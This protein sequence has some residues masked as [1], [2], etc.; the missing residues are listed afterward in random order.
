MNRSGYPAGGR[1]LSVKRRLLFWRLLYGVAR[2]LSRVSAERCR[3]YA[4]F[5]VAQRVEPDRFDRLLRTRAGEVREIGL[6]E[7]VTLPV[8]RPRS[9]I[10]GRFRQGARCL[11][12]R[13]DGEFQGFVWYQAGPY[14]EDEVRC[15]FVPEPATIAVWDFDVYVIPSARSG[16]TFARLWRGY[17]E[18][19]SSEGIEWSISRISAFNAPSVSAHATLGALHVGTACFIVLGALQIT[20]ASIAPFVHCSFGK[21]RRPVMAVQVPRIR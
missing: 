3:L 17:F 5:L 20:L 11:A 21:E 6:D 18:A 19:L 7:A 12:A 4:Y 8:P 2:V 13:R 9:A 14:E 1:R 10:V 16:S 15:R